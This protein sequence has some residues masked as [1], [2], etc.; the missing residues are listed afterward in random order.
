MAD[1]DKIKIDWD[2]INRP[3][4]TEKVERDRRFRDAEQSR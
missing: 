2:D 1:G 4:V 3:E